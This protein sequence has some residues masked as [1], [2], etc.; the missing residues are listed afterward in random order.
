MVTEERCRGMVIER[1]EQALAEA[2]QAHGKSSPQANEAA[3]ALADLYF[4]DGLYAKAELL[5]RRLVDSCT[6][7]SDNCGLIAALAKLGAVYRVERKLDDAEAVYLKGLAAIEQSPNKAR[8]RAEHISCLAGLYFE[9]GDFSQSANLLAQAHDLFQTA[10]GP[11]SSSAGL[12]DMARAL[13]CVRLGKTG[14]ADE[15][16]QR[17]RTECGATDEN[18][19]GNPALLSLCQMYFEQRRYNELETLIAGSVFCDEWQHWPKHPRVAQ[20]FF[21][22]G[23]LF[24]AQEQH[25]Q[26][27]HCFRRALEIRQEVLGP[28]HPEV[29]ATA[30]A[31][32][33]MYL[34]LN[35][36]SDAEPTLKLALKTR[37]R[38]FGVEHPG[39]AACIETYASLLRCTKRVAIAGKLDARA[40]DIRSRLV[41]AADKGTPQRP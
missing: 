40:R 6:S 16:C 13:V 39:V 35:R 36:Y 26:A 14:E 18:A 17:S 28:A 5:Y 12:V 9:K 31:L 3:N 33:V 19:T 32:A 23:E 11:D 4:Q 15:H 20:I 7:N 27:E 34:R 10:F 22:R 24:R 1:A 8:L 21:D 2:E 38:A 41:R 37:V 25:E 30:M 29:A